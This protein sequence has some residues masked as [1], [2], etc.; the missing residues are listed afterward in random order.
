MDLASLPEGLRDPRKQFEFVFKD[1]PYGLVLQ[2][3]ST[4]IIAANPAASDILGLDLDAIQGR[5]SYDGRW[6]T[7]REDGSSYPPEAHP[8]ALC[9]RVGSSVRGNVMGIWNEAESRFRWAVL[10]AFPYFGEGESAPSLALVWIGDITERVE[11]RRE[12]RRQTDR[13]G[14]LFANMTEGVALHE[15]VF[16]GEGRYVDYRILDV[17]PSYPAQ[18]GI[19]REDAIGKLGSELYGTE[20]APYLDEFCGV[21]VRQEPYQFETYFPPL[22]KHFVI[23]VA[24]LGAKGF[25]TIFFDV[26]ERKRV[27]AER[28]RLLAELERKNK[29]LESIV[30][31]ASHDLRSPLV[32][33]QGFGSRLEKDCA[34]L[35]SLAAEGPSEELRAL[36]QERIPRSLEFIRASGAKMDKLIA[37]LLRLSRT[38]RAELAMENLDVGAIVAS[39]LRSMAFQIEKAGAGIEIGLLPPCRGDPDQISAVFANLVDNAL[40]YRDPARGLSIRIAGERRGPQVEYRVEDTG[41]GIA[42]EHIEKVWELFHRLDPQDGAGGEGLGLTLVRRIVDRHGGRAWAESRLGEGSVFKIILPA[43]EAK[44]G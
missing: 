20:P 16:D 4:R 3:S 32:N 7:I 28:E 17:N 35:A 25:A 31:V 37:G 12:A 21:A 33:I 43:A 9:L 26:S 11:A 24:P 19:S 15:V 13:F 23:S 30:Y 42:S 34:R 6:R 38:G 5:D 36:A 29:E 22:D 14:S 1:S 2:D 39:I 41:R 10:D 8:A 27:E 40:K 44:N 18:V